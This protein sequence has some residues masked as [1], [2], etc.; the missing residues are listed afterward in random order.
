MKVDGIE[1]AVDAIRNGGI[2]VV[3]DDE[4]RENEGDL[5]MAAQFATTE[6]VAF[7]LEYTSGFLCTAVTEKRATQLDL[8]MMVDDN[9]EKHG[10][11]FLVSVDY[12]LGTS[13]GIS[14]A[15]RAVTARALADESTDPTLLSRPG[16]VMPYKR[17]SAVC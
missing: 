5:V 7:F 8:Q 6:S 1:A 14:A 10:T 9:T 17:E 15:D 3:V 16:H 12:R 4:S 13:T 11:A 2:V